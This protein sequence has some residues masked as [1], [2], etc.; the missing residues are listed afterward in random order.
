MENTPNNNELIQKMELFHYFTHL[1]VHLYSHNQ[2][3]L[4]FPLDL[5][6]IGNVLGNH[7]GHFLPNFLSN[8]FLSPQYLVNDY[9]EHFIIFEL[10]ETQKI[11]IGPFL[12]EP[13]YDSNLL[14]FIKRHTLSIKSKSK[15]N[16]YFAMLPIVDATKR[17][18]TTK[19]LLELFS[20][21]GL[22]PSSLT[23]NTTETSLPENYFVTTYKNRLNM[24]QHPPYFLEQVITKLIRSG[25]KAN[26]KQILSEIN[27][28]NRA[29][30]S[31][32]PLRS[33]RNSLIC[34]CTIFTRAA[35]YGGVTD[36]DAFTLSDAF[37]VEIEATESMLEL[38]KLEYRMVETFIEKVNAANTSK[39]SPII[40]NTI[41]YI[42]NHLTEK[43][44]LNDIAQ[45]VY[46]HPNYLS[47]LFKKEVGM[48]LFEYILKRRIDESTYFLKYSNE[49]I[50]DIAAL[51]QFCNQSYYIKTFNKFMHISP[52]V[53]RHSNS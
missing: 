44:V 32:N 47:S 24:F 49:S 20:S 48:S 42:M 41:T 14:D 31:D 8:Q 50:A 51:Y 46:V 23:S 25:N 4:S 33:L 6:S 36:D 26:A 21:L 28:L 27:S 53:Y 22:S 10:D 39:Y 16:D 30:L 5:I 38:N 35:I 45:N 40:R 34:S 9:Y 13:M 1:Q 11:I 29:K 18:Y 43:L 52:Y 17:L 2:L 37:I 19:L 15:L 12:A 7:E 3:T